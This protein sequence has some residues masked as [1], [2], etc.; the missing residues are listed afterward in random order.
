MTV[1]IY[2]DDLFLR[3]DTGAHPENARRLVAVVEH[4]KGAG[5]WDRCAR[6][7][8]PDATVD[9]VALV[10]DRRYIKTVLD[11]AQQGVFMV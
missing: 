2:Y 6:P 11:V 4:L 1:G 10:H 9:D 5:L 8:C 3:H 7:A